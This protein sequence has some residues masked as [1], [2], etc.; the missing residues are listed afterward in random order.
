MISRKLREISTLIWTELLLKTW[1]ILPRNLENSQKKGEI[2]VKPLFISLLRKLGN[3]QDTLEVMPN[4]AIISQKYQKMNSSSKLKRQ[5]AIRKAVTITS[6]I[7]SLKKSNTPSINN[8]PNS[9][10]LPT[11]YKR[12]NF[13]V[14]SRRKWLEVIFN[15]NL[16]VKFI[17][18]LIKSKVLSK[19]TIKYVLQNLINN[20]LT[21]Y[22]TFVQKETPES[23][24]YYFQFEVIIE[25]LENLGEKFE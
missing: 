9:L 14:N 8:K 25:F 4:S 19:K 1:R 16:D 17:A 20:F 3:N 10:N 2:S 13:W 6:S 15:H 22:Y 5:I 21:E 18:E 7:S 24:I 11:N 23:S 12:M